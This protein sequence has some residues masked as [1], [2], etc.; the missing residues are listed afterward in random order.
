MLDLRKISFGGTAAIVTSMALI[1]GLKAATASRSAVIGSL[2]IIGIADNLTDSLSVHT[3]QEAERLDQREALHTTVANFIARFLI[4]ATF[5]LIVLL[6]PAAIAIPLT[7]GW[8]FLLLAVL[9]H[10]LARV[11][12][13][14][15]AMEILKHCAVAVV[16]IAISRVIGLGLS[17]WTGGP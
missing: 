3:Y 1:V 12:H 14:S 7:I 4:S 2:L 16:V 11:R 8:G 15:S 10:L 5:I 9:S 13:V 6:L 17:V